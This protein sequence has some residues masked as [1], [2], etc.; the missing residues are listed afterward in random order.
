M[1]NF[2]TLFYR[3]MMRNKTFSII[4]IAGFT[5]S[6]TVL[7]LLSAFVFNELSYDRYN[8]NINRIYRLIRSDNNSEINEDAIEFLT[9]DFPEIESVCRYNHFILNLGYLTFNNHSITT[10]SILHT[11][12]AF[13]DIMDVEFVAGDKETALN[14]KYALVL[15]EETARKLFG[16]V[17]PMGKTVRIYHENDLTVT[18]IIKAFPQNSSMQPDAII[19][20]DL[21]TFTNCW[22]SEG[23]T[24]YF[25][26]FFV[27]VKPGTDISLLGEKISAHLMNH[28]MVDNPV[29]LTP[30]KNSYIGGLRDG[31]HLMHTN[32]KLI[33]ILSGIVLLV[34]LISILNFIILFTAH[35]MTRTKEI[36]LKKTIGAGSGAIFMQFILESVLIG[37]I[38][39]II[40]VILSNTVHP[41]FESIVDK[42]FPLSALYSFPNVLCIPA[43]L[44]ILSIIAG[45]FPAL[46]ASRFSVLSMF[47]NVNGNAMKIKSWLLTVQYTVSIMLIVALL[48][49]S[50]Q[51]DYVKHK[52]LGFTTDSLVRMEISYK[53]GQKLQTLR[54]ELQRLSGI[55]GVTASHGGPGQ[56]NIGMGWQEAKEAGVWQ[57][58]VPA[59]YIDTEF[60]KVFDVPIIEGRNFSSEENSSE[61][62]MIINETARRLINWDTIEGK[63]IAGC[64]VIGVVKDFYFA[65]LYQCMEPAFFIYQARNSFSWLS[66][67][68][69]P[70]DVAGTLAAVK[71][72]WNEVCPEF[73][74]EYQFYDEWVD[75]I[76][77]AEDRLGYAIRLFT[78]IAIL[79]TCMGTFGV[80]QFSTRRRRKE[81][82]IRKVNGASVREITAML[83]KDFLKWTAIAFCA[84]VPAS[85]YLMHLWLR[86]FAYRTELAWWIF[87]LAGAFAAIIAIITTSWQVI[88]AAQANPI[89]TLRYE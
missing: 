6:L 24:I 37:G 88:R 50:R 36:G 35:Y 89:E 66:L 4:T 86:N 9:H 25:N 8:T 13:F 33:Y 7:I 39:F 72:V 77:K 53:L 80:V 28:K 65:D 12:P 48:V 14:D 79:I 63:N 60:F 34:L 64:K 82:G 16:D 58:A 59:F 56:I 20:R 11:E 85:W 31:S 87:V 23:K 81:V 70:N 2:I 1:K 32:I 84:A 41:L 18:G 71:Q 68:I 51:L 46:L 62:L 49:I 75:A 22:M 52:D 74:Y 76:Y 26:R 69:T 38:A 67:R 55:T 45:L 54:N 57:E 42:R 21:K 83:N 17:D 5:L 43:G 10:K 44:I 40:A 29:F 73:V 47:R 3:N 19:Q 78:I 27:M 30:H 15:T 61:P